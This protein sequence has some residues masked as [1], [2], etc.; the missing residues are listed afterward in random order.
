MKA[1]AESG[2]EINIIDMTQ[3]DEYKLLGVNKYA[4]TVNDSAYPNSDEYEDEIC[5]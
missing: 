2:Y 4:S 5:D 1:E 3:V